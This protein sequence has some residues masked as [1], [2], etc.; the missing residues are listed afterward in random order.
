M[1]VKAVGQVTPR[2]VGQRVKRYDGM[3]HVTGETRFVDDVI[4]PGTLMVKA[5]RSPVHKGKIKNID[6]S[7][8]ESMIGVAGVITARDVPCNAYGLIPDQPVLAAESVRYK[9]EPI[10]AVAAVD[11]DVALAALDKIKIDIEEEEPVF[12]PLEAMKPEAPKVRPEGNIFMFGE[13]P[14]RQIV[15]GDIDAGFRDADV[16]VESEYLHPSLEH[17]QIEPM[18]SLAV[19]E[20]SGKLK[21]YTCSQALYFHLGMLCGILQMDPKDVRCLQWAARTGSSWRHNAGFGYINYVG[22]TVGGAFGAK[23]D[24]HTDHVTAILALKTGRPCKWRWTREEDLLYS[25]FRGA[26]K[27]KYKDGVK[28]DGRI[29]ARKIESIRE[30]GAYTSLNSYV[31]DKHC[32]LATGP[33][34][35][36]NV[37]IQGYCVYT[38]KPPASSMRGFGVTPATFAT[39]VQISKVAEA[40]GIDPWE[41]RFINAYRKGDQTPTRRVIN[42]VALVEVMQKLAKKAGVDLPSRLRSMNSEKRG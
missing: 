4:V 3:A 7:G 38:N 18:S 22:G 26:W 12:D 32:Y 39:E 27:M 21:V 28:K 11:E 9:G 1:T 33:Y 25:T 2:V 37:Y 24:I 19:P 13:R 30:A 14:Y 35:V 23:N 36:P 42:S 20:A 17:A 40:I 16:V 5:L 34:F 6:A 15:F 8:A 31:V 29:V 10:A 41:I